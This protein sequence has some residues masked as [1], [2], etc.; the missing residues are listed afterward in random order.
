MKTNGKGRWIKTAGCLLAGMCSLLSAGERGEY[1]SIALC[2]YPSAQL[3]R[4][5]ACVD[6]DPEAGRRAQE[7]LQVAATHLERS[8]KSNLLGI[9]IEL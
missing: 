9:I 1:H 4:I 2:P 7:L 6:S 3:K 5:R 8:P